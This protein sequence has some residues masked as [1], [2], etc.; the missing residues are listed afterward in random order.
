[1]QTP[2]SD[3]K[4]TKGLVYFARMLDKIRLKARGELPPD[5]FT[6][7]DEDPTM[8]DTPSTRFLA[9]IYDELVDPTLKGGSEEEIIEWGFQRGR[10]PGEQEIKICDAFLLNS[11]RREEG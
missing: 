11:G 10:K 5:Y 4:E 7:L 2:V 8:F 1:M 9:V 6:G 3:Y